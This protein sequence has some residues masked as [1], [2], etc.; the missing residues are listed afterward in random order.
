M[1]WGGLISGRCASMQR[2]ARRVKTAYRLASPCLA[3]SAPSPPTGGTTPRWTTRSINDA[4]RLTRAD[5]RQLSRPGF[6]VVFY[7]TLEDFYLAEALEYIDAWRQA[8]A[9]NPVGI[10]GPIGPDRATAAR[11]A[12]RQRARPGRSTARAFLGHGRVVRSER[13]GREV[14]VTH[15]LSFERADRELCFNRIRKK[16][17][18]PDA[19][20]HFPK[21][22]TTAYRKAGTR[23]CAAP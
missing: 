14:P 11:R 8:T 5:L 18:M 1:R 17:C 3:N 13:Q 16:L 22:D 20:L 4:A 7:D 2:S 6:K 12:A 10:C 9:D 23:A 15:P 21:A 19:N